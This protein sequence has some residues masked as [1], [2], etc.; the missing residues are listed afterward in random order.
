M[1]RRQVFGISAAGAVSAA[2]MIKGT[3]PHQEPPPPVAQASKQIAGYYEKPM[4]SAQDCSSCHFYISPD[5][6]VLVNGPVS[7][8]GY[9]NYYS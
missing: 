8:W 2:S 1:D 7:P 4:G 5:A 3:W 6:C 9:C